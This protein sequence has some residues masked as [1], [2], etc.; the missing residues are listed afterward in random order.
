MWIQLYINHT[1]TYDILILLILIYTVEYVG[2]FSRTRT[3]TFKASSTTLW[4]ACLLVICYR[5]LKWFIFLCDYEYRT[6]KYTDTH[7]NHIQILNNIF[8]HIKHKRFPK[9]ILPRVPTTWM[10]LPKDI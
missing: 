2:V 3:G 1:H 6:N 8:S 7:T 5:N 9:D 10:F 4:Y